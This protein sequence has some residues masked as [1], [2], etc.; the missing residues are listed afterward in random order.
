MKPLLLGGT[1]RSPRGVRPLLRGPAPERH[2]RKHQWSIFFKLLICLL[3]ALQDASYADPKYSDHASSKLTR[4]LLGAELALGVDHLISPPEDGA[5]RYLERIFAKDPANSRAAEVLNQP[6]ARFLTS[7]DAVHAPQELAR[8]KILKAV[9][10]TARGDD[11][12]AHHARETSTL[13]ASELRDCHVSLGLASLQLGEPA[14]AGRQQQ[15]AADLVAQYQ[16]KGGGVSYLAQLLEQGKAPRTSYEWKRYAGQNHQ[17][18]RINE[19]LVR[20]HLR[21]E[22]TELRDCHVSLGLASLQLGEPAEAGRQQQAAADL[23]AQYQLK[24]GGVSYLAQLLEQ[25]KAPRTSYE[26]KHYAGQN[27]QSARINEDLVRGHLRRELT[28]LRD[29][30]VSLGLASLQLGE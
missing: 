16:L 2:P 25:G 8:M 12:I 11:A 27:H 1:Q 5:L 10:S 9:S 3:L 20:G 24:G 7:N 19:D 4:Y 23:V 15:A 17:S 29:C 13:V 14:E 28:E 30:H 26:W 21:R 18:A 6:I 22:L